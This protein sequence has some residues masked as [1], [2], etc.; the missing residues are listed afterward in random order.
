MSAIG[1]RLHDVFA[2]I[3]AINAKDPGHALVDGAPTPANL[4]YGRRM[5]AELDAYCPEASGELKIAA[6]GQHI[7]RWIIPRSAYPMDRAGYHAWRNALRDHHAQRLAEILAR[8]GY[9]DAFI[10]RVQAIVRKER[11]RVDPD[12]QVLEDVI[13]LVFLKFELNAFA[14][15]LHGDETRLG[16]ILAKTWRKMSA[17]AQE[18]ALAIPPAPEVVRM[19]EAGLA[20]Q[21]AG[22][23]G[24]HATGQ[25][26]R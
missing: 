23:N 25:T 20:R 22:E 4:A 24:R 8:A 1:S 21:T 3:D 16:D 6:R 18:T 7:E 14:A 15:K 19:L 5:S 2:E 11:L 17:R 12:V 10:R 26:G 13:C 9:H